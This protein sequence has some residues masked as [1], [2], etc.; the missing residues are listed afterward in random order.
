VLA[1]RFGLHVFALDAADGLA[2]TDVRRLTA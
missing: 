1:R 2:L